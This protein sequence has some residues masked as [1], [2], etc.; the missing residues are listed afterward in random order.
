MQFVCV[1]G[2]AALVNKIPAERMHRF[3]TNTQ[4]LNVHLIIKMTV[5]LTD[6]EGHRRKSKVT[7]MNYWSYLA[8]YYIRRHHTCYQGTIQQATSNDI[9]LFDLEG[10]DHN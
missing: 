5:T 7:Q 9:S 6:N 8:N 2:S 10:Q 4:E 3:G 1:S